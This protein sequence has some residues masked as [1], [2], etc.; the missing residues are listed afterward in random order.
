MNLY[1][2]RKT[3]AETWTDHWNLID[4]GPLYNHAMGTVNDVATVTGFHNARAILLDDL[5]VAIEFGMPDDPFD[6]RSNWTEDWAPFPDPKIRGEFADLFY[7]GALVDRVH[8][9]SVDGGR[10]ILPLP[11][12]RDGE[13]ITLDWPYEMARVVD[14]LSGSHDFVDYFARSGLRKWPA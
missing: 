5:D 8:L 12:R 3:V 9:A 1:D 14:D 11:E 13:W 6:A 2:L 4:N 10:A 7:R